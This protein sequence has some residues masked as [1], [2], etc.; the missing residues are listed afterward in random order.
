MFKHKYENI[1]NSLFNIIFNISSF[2]AAKW[3][4]SLPEIFAT[5]CK[6]QTFNISNLLKSFNL[7]QIKVWNIFFMIGF[8]QSKLEFFLLRKS[9]VVWVYIDLPGGCNL[10]AHSPFNASFILRRGLTRFQNCF[11]GLRIIECRIPSDILEWGQG[12]IQTGNNT[13]IAP[14]HL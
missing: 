13:L 11:L 6:V 14:N 7:K 1:N 4:E 3:I 2:K 10:A 9:G 5:I 8:L 12:A